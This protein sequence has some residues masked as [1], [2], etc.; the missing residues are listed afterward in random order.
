MFKENRP[1]TTQTNEIETIIGP[2]VKVEGDFVTEGNMIVEGTVSGSIRTERNL[3]VGSKSKIFANVSAENALIAGEVQGNIRVNN[4][5]ELLSTAK[6][7]GDVKAEV[8]IISAGSVFNGKCQMGESKNKSPRPDSARQEKIEL[9][10]AEPEMDR[11]I[12]KK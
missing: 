8:L 1:E 5:L 11:I 2:S 12:K 9:K 3:K 4:K 6:V 10:P 7:F